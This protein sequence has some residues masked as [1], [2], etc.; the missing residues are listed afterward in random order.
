MTDK[1]I[2]SKKKELMKERWTEDM[3]HSLKDFEPEIAKK[4]IDSMTDSDIYIRVNQRTFQ[5]DYIADY[6]RFL[7]DISE[8]GFWKHIIISLDPEIGILWGDHMPHFEKM[9]SNKLPDEVLKKIIS[10]LIHYKSEFKNQYEMD[11]DAIGCVFK[12]QIND[13][14]RLNEIK[15]HIASLNIENKDEVIQKIESFAT[16]NC[17]YNF[18]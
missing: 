13:F 1:E 4:I 9:C 18:Y 14:N 8:E 15:E 10:F 17:K 2:K 5:E 16:S 6:L 12:A 7:W 11:I 3:H